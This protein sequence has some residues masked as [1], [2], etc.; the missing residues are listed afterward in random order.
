MMK[1]IAYMILVP[2]TLLFACTPAPQEAYFN[3]GEPESLLDLATKAVNL[4]IKSPASIQQMTEV[5]S[6]EQPNHAKLSCEKSSPLC[7][8]AKHVLTQFDVPV[9]YTD[10]LHSKVSLYYE[11]MKVRNCQNRYIDNTADLNSM[12]SP[13]FGCS[14]ASN[15]VQMI[16]DKRQILSPAMTGT[17]DAI[18]PLQVMSG[19]EM[20]NYT[21]T[22]NASTEQS[23]QLLTT[24]AGSSR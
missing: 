11:S 24:N 3:R 14:T 12:N 20:P 22:N 13:T 16:T 10:S 2:G 1:K 17:A 23:T 6:K 7:R 8:E 5:I 19:Y 21:A 18:K 9:E 15:M 4:D